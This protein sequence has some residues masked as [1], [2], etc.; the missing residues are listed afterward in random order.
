ME[1][2]PGETVEDLTVFGGS[3]S[4]RGKVRRDVVVFGGKLNVEGEIGGDAVVFG[5]NIHLQT[6]ATVRGDAVVFLGGTKLETN[7]TI[8]GD[9]VSFGGGVERAE[10][11]NVRGD[12]V[13]FAFPGTG[14]ELPHW[15]ELWFKQCVLKLR[16]L[17]PSVGWVWMFAGAFLLLYILIA[18]AF[19]KPVG[20]CVEALN[21]SPV[22][23]FL[24][25]LLMKLLIPFVCLLLA[26]TGI[27]VLVLPFL[28]V[29]LMLA[30]L[31]G[32]VALLEY[33]GLSFIRQVS[34]GSVQKPLIG[35]ALGWLFIT[36][37]YMIPVLGLI[38]YGVLG[39]WGLGCVVTATFGA[40]RREKPPKTPQAAMPFV[41]G[42]GSGPGQGSSVGA[43]AFVPGSNPVP[44][45]AIGEQTAPGSATGFA[46]QAPTPAMPAGPSAAIPENL[47]YPRAGFWERLAAGFLDLI[48]VS[49]LAGLTSSPPLPLEH[50]F[51]GPSLGL[52]ITLAYFAGMWAWKGTTVGGVVLNLKVVRFDGQ[53]LTFPVA[54]VRALAGAF[55]VVVL[56]LGFL[57]IAWD[58]ENQGWHD[59]VAG[60][61]VVR[62]PRGNPLICI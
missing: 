40:M 25:G 23:T 30:S 33:F 29:A 1:V 7:A 47:A 27:G 60:T 44:S 20:V 50:H 38:T 21:R 26:I 34:S 53:P 61:L 6:N 11:A 9:A 24:L 22:T 32:K 28:G 51:G 10:G 19:A 4:V 37:L 49:I 52:L 58:R 54:L 8:H 48:L 43:T 39:L 12:V 5:G 2:K 15:L 18:A 46:P 13:P 14:G 3:A 42:P 55:S 16:P 62:L 59:K 17:A 31:V 35:F 36:L 45:T 41:P 57:W 56:F